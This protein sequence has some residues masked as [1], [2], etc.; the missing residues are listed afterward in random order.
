MKSR[1]PD[2]VESIF[3]VLSLDGFSFIV[4][5]CGRSNNTVGSRVGLYNLE[6]YGP[7]ASSHDEGVP[8]VDGSALIQEVGLQVNLEP[9][10]C[11]TFHTVV[12]REN[13]DPISVLHVR[14][15]LNN[16]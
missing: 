9:V 13:V 6:L 16:N 14:A 4:D 3:F 2:S 15:G 1:L 7:H 5:N 12:D 11:Q 10:S 8:L